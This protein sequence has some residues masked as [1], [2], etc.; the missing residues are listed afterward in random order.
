MNCTRNYE[1]AK[2][3]YRGG[4]ARKEDYDA[5]LR[6]HQAA[7]DATKST[8]REEAYAFDNLSSEEKRLTQKRLVQNNK[9]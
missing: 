4:Y 8:Q 1:Q 5:A 6:G 3:A 7:V 2:E 9:S